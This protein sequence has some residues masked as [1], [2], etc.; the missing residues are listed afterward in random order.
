MSR[1][2]IRG[3]R[4]L[5]VWQKAMRLFVGTSRAIRK[6]PWPEREDIGRQMRR[7]AISIPSNIA[8][9][10]GRDH[11]GDFLRNLSTARGE[12]AEL[13][14]QLLA[15]RAIA[16]LPKSELQPLLALADEISRMLAVL[17]QK[18][19]PRHDLRLRSRSR[20]STRAHLETRNSKLETRNSKLE[21][22][23]LITAAP[24]RKSA[25]DSRHPP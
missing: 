20:P 2:I 3:Y 4:D 11:L 12:V 16:L 8:E 19:R 5:I 22:G 13:E 18:L 7:A 24:R 25:S 14:T 23:D 9:G 6:M 15:V 21:T 10:A 17:S 1:P